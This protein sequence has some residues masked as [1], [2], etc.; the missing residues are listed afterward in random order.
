MDQECRG[1]NR[2][3][4][5]PYNIPLVLLIFFSAKNLP[6]DLI[7][8]PMNNTSHFNI[9]KVKATQELIDLFDLEEGLH[10]FVK[11][12]L[13]GTQYYRLILDTA[14]VQML[15]EVIQTID[16][17]VPHIKIYLSDYIL[18]KKEPTKA[19]KDLINHFTVDQLF[20]AFLHTPRIIAL[21]K[22]YKQPI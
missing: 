14:D 13:K 21:R 6:I 7:K 15:H 9:L 10:Y 4:Y 19:I 16:I 5:N 8:S 2:N 17:Y 20:G 22:K 11:R 3:K 12:T 1:N 18:L